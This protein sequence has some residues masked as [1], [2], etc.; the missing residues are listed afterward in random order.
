MRGKK[1]KGLS[2]L[3]PLGVIDSRRVRQRPQQAHP[4]Q[5][6]N[7]GTKD[8]RESHLEICDGRTRRFREGRQIIK[9]SFIAQTLALIGR[10]GPLTLAIADQLATL[11][12]RKT[13]NVRVDKMLRVE[14]AVRNKWKTECNPQVWSRISLNS[15]CD[16]ESDMNKADPHVHKVYG[17]V[18]RQSVRLVA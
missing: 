3:F 12:S 17:V 9:T 18:E 11:L 5:Q 4:T 2:F 8:K 7:A 6:D 1:G 14:L 13:G 16:P 15:C 10:P